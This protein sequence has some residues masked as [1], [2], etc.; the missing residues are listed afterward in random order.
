MKTFF[1][2]TLFFVFF[3]TS[4]LSQSN[5]QQSLSVNSSGAAADA[6]AQLDVSASDKGVLVP[7]MTSAQRTA[8]ASPATGLLVFDTTTGDFW[9]YT[10]AAWKN[11][12]NQKVLED[13][14]GN[15]KVQV[16]KNPNE[17][18]IRFDLG[19]TEN[20]VL[21]K[22]AS[23]VARLELPSAIGNHFMGQGAGTANT[24]G[25]SNTA[26]G[27]DAL[28]F[29]TTGGNNTANGFEAL[30]NNSTGANNTANGRYA[31]RSNSTGGSNTANGAEALFA[32]TA[33]NSNT[34]IGVFALTSNTTGNSNAA[35]GANA[36][37]ANT[38]GAGNTAAGLSALR[39]NTTGFSNVAIGTHSLYQNT[40]R[41]NLVAIGDSALYNNGIGA[42]GTFAAT[43]NIAVGTKT[44]FSN[45]TGYANVAVGTKTLFSNTTGYAN[46]AVGRAALSSN[47]VNDGNTAV[48]DSSLFSNKAFS[49]AAPYIGNKNTAI[50]CRAMVKN[51]AG[52]LNTANGFEAL[53]SNTIGAFNTATGV[54]A[55]YSNTIGNFNT[56]LGYGADVGANSLTNATAIGYYALVNCSNCMA[57]GSTGTLAVNVGIGTTTPN[58][59]LSVSPNDIESKITLW[60]GGSTTNH[61]GFG[62]SG[63]QLN[64]HVD[65]SSTSHVFYAGGK[66]GNGTELMR[67]SGNG[68]V[69]IGTTTPVNRLT[70]IGS[71]N[72]PTIPGTTSTGIVRIGVSGIEGIDIGKL[73][74]SPY[75]GWIQAGIG[76]NTADPLTL[77]PSGGRVGI[78]RN[79]LTNLLEVQGDASKTT[80]GDWLANSDARLKKN[81]L[82]LNSEEMLQKMLA[83]QGVTYEW[84]DDKTGS[85]RPTGT[86]FGFIAQNIQEVFP[87]LV[88]ADALGFLQ[89]AYG[90]YDAMTVEAIR[91]LHDKIQ[92]LEAENAAQRSEIEK[93]T[94]NVAENASLKAQL[95]SQSVLLEKI[96][97]AL[98]GAGIA[99]EK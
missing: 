8:I 60:D 34:A 7:R 84:N 62:V 1:L 17:D 51:H 33:G 75:S 2:S 72:N 97:A 81:I 26:T 50:G 76:G 80:A 41:G 24:T 45:T 67:V 57:L 43:A 68:N 3:T 74:V 47:E 18:V 56:A 13:A 29:N 93:L 36:L 6:S 85:Q 14:D 25:H 69:S 15:T 88:E 12:S 40:V 96:G 73:G 63:S 48:G 89:T 91:A 52:Y 77:Q 46:V 30:R 59:R 61:Y 54:G 94:A 35:L 79:A 44:L 65:A 70:T 19:G 21:R 38:T 78:G 87:T 23:G 55:L 28:R 71:A 98:Q 95:H 39:F 86:H 37:Y 16:E 49:L 4:L 66:N 42:S 53:Y 90:T 10:G 82:P 58:T 27:S 31:L 83:L 92:S 22:N 99:V 32:N 5:I 11:L 20:M 9:F 64:Y